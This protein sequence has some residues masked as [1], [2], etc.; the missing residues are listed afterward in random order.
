M[1]EI[2]S[3]KNLSQ[4]SRNLEEKFLTWLGNFFASKAF[5]LC[6]S[7][8]IFLLSIYLRS[9]IDTGQDTNIYI[10]LGQRIAQGGKYYDT[11]LESNMPILFY[12]YAL[13]YRLSLFLHI[14]PI[15][16]SEIIVNLLGILSI[17]WS[18]K[19]LKKT[20][21]YDNKAH[22]NLIL[23]AFFLSFFLRPYALQFGE[24][25]TKSSFLLACFFP[26]LS[27][28][29]T[30][31]KSFS[32][33]DLIW[34]G[35]LMGLIPCLKPHYLIL[36]IF[37]EIAQIF[38]QK[39]FKEKIKFCFTLDKLIML[40]I[41]LLYIN[42]LF[43]YVPEF[44]ELMV[45][46]WSNIYASYASFSEFVNK[47]FYHLSFR[48]TI[49]AFIF[50]TFARLKPS[51]DDV[52]LLFAFLGVSFLIIFESIATIDQS[53]SFY[54]VTTIVFFKLF[55]D[56]IASRQFS[57]SDNKF[58]IIAL[59]FLPFFNIEVISNSVFGI[60]GLIDAWWVV[61]LIFPF[62]FKKKGLSFAVVIIYAA[63]LILTI[64]CTKYF[65]GL[66]F[67]AANALS[68]FII[69]FFYEKSQANISKKFSPFF[70]FIVFASVS[71]LFHTYFLSVKETATQSGYN[72]SPN[73]LN[74]Q[75]ISY[76]K[77]YAPKKEDDVIIF[78]RQQMVLLLNY[79]EKDNRTKVNFG[80]TNAFGTSSEDSE[81]RKNHFVMF[82]FLKNH[83]KMLA[84][85]YVFD[86]IKHQIK[87][88]NAKVLFL[89]IGQDAVEGGN[90]CT[91]GYLEYYF[92][93]PEFKKIFLQNYVFKGRIIV[94][95]K[96]PEKIG[97]KW[98]DKNPDIFDQVP[99]S[100]EVISEDFEVY[101]RK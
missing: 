14:N 9:A 12:I 90:R 37:I 65:G 93:D 33:Q 81:I 46:M 54:T 7:S 30:F 42:L 43:K 66:G 101:V 39:T 4:I 89:N 10:S 86:N 78:F 60:G 50:L 18:A 21:I 28:S 36:I 35:I 67:V 76:A 98:V 75:I 38:Y 17:F 64:L 32:T 84:L 24:F 53:V 70:V 83:D 73:Q 44:F 71:Y 15:I 34:R 62:L 11:F 100:K 48:I 20:T 87:N 49:F 19:I 72:T 56:L 6:F 79:M 27:Y 5:L 74:D 59:F 25:G 2:K 3:K 92:L 82:P 40:M 99:S 51:R 68:L 69:L 23:V 88:K 85:S 95:K 94:T 52:V 47:I 29:F 57:F 45:P 91:I 96:A 80:I 31:K 8:A 61:A 13:E 26:Y 77:V 22:Y 16:T 1:L 55:Y 41:G 97:M 63:L 58:I